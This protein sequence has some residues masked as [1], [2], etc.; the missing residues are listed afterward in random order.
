MPGKFINLW[1][2]ICPR[3]PSGARIQGSCASDPGVVAGIWP[4]ALDSCRARRGRARRVDCILLYR[5]QYCVIHSLALFVLCAVLCWCTSLRPV[6][7][8]EL[9][10]FD[11]P[12]GSVHV[13]VSTPVST[14]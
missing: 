2:Y 12:L 1:L 14:G 13:Y 6:F 4:D 10:Q 9:S 7:G 5:L 11:V 3:A 8:R